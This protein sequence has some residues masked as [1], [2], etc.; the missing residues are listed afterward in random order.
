MLQ[1]ELGN[2]QQ[3]FFYTLDIFIMKVY[4]RKVKS[5]AA[6]EETLLLER[7]QQESEIL[8]SFS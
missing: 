5:H 2:S 7:T 8:L 3:P 4:S 1:C 6:S